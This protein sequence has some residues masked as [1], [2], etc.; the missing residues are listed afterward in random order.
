MSKLFSAYVEIVIRV[1]IAVVHRKFQKFF[2]MYFTVS[3]LQSIGTS[4]ERLTV[5]GANMW[6][7][8]KPEMAS[9]WTTG[10]GSFWR[11]AHAHKNEERAEKKLGR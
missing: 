6:S 10:R 2:L 1:E 11:I 8:C 9:A 3:N 5:E 7:C 4:C